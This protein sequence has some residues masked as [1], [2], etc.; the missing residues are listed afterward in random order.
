MSGRIG[1]PDP[2]EFSGVMSSPGL[3]GGNSYLDKQ[4]DVM[5]NFL[6][7]LKQQR[8]DPT[9]KQEVEDTF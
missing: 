4:D 1:A 8:A 7:N 5:N 6:K 3:Y 9:P 2:N